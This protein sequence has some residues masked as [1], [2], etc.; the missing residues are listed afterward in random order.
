MKNIIGIVKEL[1]ELQKA[2]DGNTM[3]TT[4]SEQF[5]FACRK[6][7]PAIAQALLIAVEALETFQ[8]FPMDQDDGVRAKDIADKTMARI[9]SLPTP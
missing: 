5:Y 8:R 7:V 3:F 6:H 4:E 1:Q 9:R 2:T